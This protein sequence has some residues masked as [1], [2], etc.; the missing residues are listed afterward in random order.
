MYSSLPRQ[1]VRTGI[2]KV[3][4]ISINSSINSVFNIT[5]GYVNTRYSNLGVVAIWPQLCQILASSP[6]LD[7]NS[8]G[9]FIN[10][11]RI[12]TFI[13]KI[14][15]DIGTLSRRNGDLFIYLPHIDC[16]RFSDFLDLLRK[17]V[18]EVKLVNTSDLVDCPM[19][20]GQ[21]TI[22]KDSILT[23]LNNL[24]RSTDFVELSNK[25]LN[26]FNSM[27]HLFRSDTVQS[28]S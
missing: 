21:V 18:A 2:L 19:L 14:I 27:G 17:L 10:A 3:D 15:L 8:H 25:I 23:L 12:P 20:N 5:S 22:I 7:R 16:I 26:E 9:S 1:V 13:S 4:S 28:V 24:L 11:T 6:V